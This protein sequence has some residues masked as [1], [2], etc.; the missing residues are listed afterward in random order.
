MT[1]IGTN[2]NRALSTHPEDGSVRKLGC[3]FIK[4]IPVGGINLVH[5]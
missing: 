5:T 2:V 3:G 1:Q 4:W